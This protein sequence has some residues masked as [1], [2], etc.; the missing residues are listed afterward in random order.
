MKNIEEEESKNGEKG[1]KSPPPPPYVPNAR[2][3]EE[4]HERIWRGEEGI[5]SSP[6]CTNVHTRERRR[7]HGMRGEF[8]GFFKKEDVIVTHSLWMTFE[9]RDGEDGE[10]A[11]K[12]RKL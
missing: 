12:E 10:E 1:E 3:K 4:G 11:K 7:E 5:S 8:M 9:D 6:L 2:E